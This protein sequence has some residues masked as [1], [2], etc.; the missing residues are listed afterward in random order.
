MPGLIERPLD[1]ATASTV[2]LCEDT[3]NSRTTC[4]NEPPSASTRSFAYVMLRASLVI[5]ASVCALAHVGLDLA[6][7]AMRDEEASHL[8]ICARSSQT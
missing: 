5:G 4:E 1:A 2:D 8:A 7:I 3:A 6:H